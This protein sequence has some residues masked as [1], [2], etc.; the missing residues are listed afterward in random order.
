MK[1]LSRVFL[2]VVMLALASLACNMLGSGAIL[3]DDFSGS[4]TN[5]GTGT[6]SNSSVEY[7]NDALNFFVNKDYYFVWSTPDDVEYENVHIEASV[8]N[9]SVDP[10]GAFGIVCNLQ[11]V[12]DTSYYFAVTGAGEY[13]IG[14]Y[15]LT[16]DDILTN[17]GQWGTSD[18]IKAN[19]ASYRIGADC[20][21][22]GTLTLSV[23]GQ[24]VDSVN[25]TMYLTGQVALF[26]WSGEQTDGTNVSFDDFVM[27]KLK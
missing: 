8:A 17:D 4:D 6:D 15:T 12:T 9:T 23:N 20:A 14:R 16:S 19:E 22:D 24:K 26:A 11:D 7:S 3:E 27:T 25:D 5:W 2:A 10:T 13:A 21:S 18:A 1:K